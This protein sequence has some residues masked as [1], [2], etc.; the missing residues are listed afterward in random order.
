M[1]ELIEKLN[2]IKCGCSWWP[3]SSSLPKV[4]T[5]CK[6]K[7]WNGSYIADRGAG[8]PSLVPDAFVSL[9]VGCDVVIRWDQKV[10]AAI[11]RYAKRTNKE[12]IQNG[13]IDQWTV[14]RRK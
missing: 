3:R 13:T 2:C 6:S 12:L 1:S 5:K 9:A 11:M 10:I 4:C 7:N 8:R 14:Y